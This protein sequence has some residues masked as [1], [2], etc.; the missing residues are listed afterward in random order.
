MS[1]MSDSSLKAKAKNLARKSALSPQ[2]VLQMHMMERLLE[3]FS[4]SS[5]ADNIIL[6]GGLLIASLSGVAQRTTR[7]MDATLTDMD[8]DEASV[9]AMMEEVC[10]V[11]VGDAVDCEL[12][13]IETIREEDEYPGFRAHV[14]M[15]FGKIATTVK[16]DI[17]TGDA[18]IPEPTEYLYEPILGGEVI[19]VR[20]YAPET[21]LAEKFETVVRR[22]TLNGRARDFYDVVLLTKLK[23]AALDDDALR[24]AVEATVKRRGSEAALADYASVLAAVRESEYINHTIWEPYVRMNPY[25]ASTTIDEAVRTCLSIAER[26]GL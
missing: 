11:S 5:Y 8:V 1:A 18:M 22:G 14:R 13:G 9:R 17:T 16:V 3:R 10:A 23:G 12:T 6:K 4:R 7:D 21:V 26:I 24:A 19:R 20:S 2:E 15:S 25:A